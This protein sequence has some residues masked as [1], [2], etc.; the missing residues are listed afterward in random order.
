MLR[1]LRDTDAIPTQLAAAIEEFAD[2]YDRSAPDSTAPNEMKERIAIIENGLLTQLHRHR[3]I[4]EMEYEFDAHGLWHTHGLLKET[5]IHCD[6][7]T[8]NAS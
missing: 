7:G 5:S 6:F 1:E 3:L 2:I 4:V 8:P